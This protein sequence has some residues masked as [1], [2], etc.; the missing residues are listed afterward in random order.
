MPRQPIWIKEDEAAKMMDYAPAS[1]RRR[2][3]DGRLAIA[4]TSIN[5][6]KYKYDKTDI[7]NLLLKHSTFIK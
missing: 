1:L 4:Y 7:Q 6:R 5:N 3:K 2:V